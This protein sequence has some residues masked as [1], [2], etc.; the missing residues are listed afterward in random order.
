RTCSVTGLYPQ[1][2]NPKS[3]QNLARSLKRLP[4]TSPSSNKKYSI[5]S[6]VTSTLTSFLLNFSYLI[7]CLRR[8]SRCRVVDNFYWVWESDRE[9][10]SLRVLT[11]PHPVLV[12][13]DLEV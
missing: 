4:L 3:L 12:L 1:I 5:C 10:L 8:E 6:S 9:N 2:P 7:V 11:Y 13:G